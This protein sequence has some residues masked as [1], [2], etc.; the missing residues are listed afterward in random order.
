M[1]II[2]TAI[3]SLITLFLLKLFLKGPISPIK[4]DMSGKT[5]IITGASSGI[6]KET[7]IE[8][9]NQGAIVICASRNQLESIKIIKKSKNPQNGQY[10]F[11]DLSSIKSV[12]DFVE[13][14]KKDFPKGIDILIN[15]AGQCFSYP[16]LS[17]DKLDKAI[18]TNFL[19]HFILTSLLI[20]SLKNKG[21]IINVSSKGY[22]YCTYSTIED[23]EKD[24]DFKILDDYYDVLR[25]YGFAKLC[26]I[27]YA[28][29]LSKN[30][31]NITSISLHPGF[32]FTNLWYNTEGISYFC[33]FCFKPLFYFLLR[34]EK[35]GAQNTLYLCYE[36]NENINNGKYYRD[37]KEEDTIGISN[38]PLI[39][40]RLMS[41]TKNI[42]EK[43]FNRNLPKDLKEHLELIEK[44]VN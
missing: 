34:S 7:A 28:R 6:G 22:K 41:Y 33:F 23:L 40:K 12:L 42:I 32:S 13:K 26:A 43:Y 8:L 16:Y 24:M 11:L 25:N 21:K 36:E 44:M 2:F 9:L 18:Q 31:K 5:I 20:K 30:F 19:G 15:N 17:N 10:Y 38:D 3:I 14:I 37:F 27:I 1:D 39:E 35:M 4:K 29:F